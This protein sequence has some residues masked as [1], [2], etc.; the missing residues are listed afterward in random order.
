[1]NR[2]WI[3]CSPIEEIELRVVGA[4]QPRHPTTVAHGFRVGPSLRTCGS[5]FGRAIPAPLDIARLRIAG[6]EETRY[7]ERI[8]AD[9]DDD[10]IADNQGRRC[11]EVLLLHVGDLNAP[12][13]FAGVLVERDQK[14]VRRFKEQPV[15][16][17]TD[18]AIP[19]V[20]S[21]GGLP[22][23][24]PKLAAGS[25]VDRPGMIGHGEVQNAI[26]QQR[27]CLDLYSEWIRFGP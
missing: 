3:P 16:I 23:E 11:G 5:W 15:S 6:F 19:N 25:S 8:A 14:V 20:D 7:V 4:G 27:R 1:M 2:I 26:D 10:V 22:L 12:A 9:S 17:D 13:Q 18:S 21:A 24:M